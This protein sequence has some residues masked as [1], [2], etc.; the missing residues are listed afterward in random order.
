MTEVQRIIG[1]DNGL[2]GGIV[3]LCPDGAVLR[4][5]VMPTVKLG[6]RRQYDL[7]TLA[8]LF[9][10]A[11]HHTRCAV[12]IEQSKPMPRVM[13]G[14]TGAWS[15]GYTF[16]IAIGMLAALRISYTVVRPQEWQRA[17]FAGLPAD[18]TTKQKSVIVA[19]RLWPSVDWT[20]SERA[21]KAHDGMTDAAL[22]AEAGRRSLGTGV[23]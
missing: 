16:G 6:K 14:V 12:F 4:A 22:I 13:K 20:R 15:S 18:A 3:S 19:Q 5:D 8:D 23:V 10:Y 17:M 9:N 21:T 7:V 1:I 2:D 11:A